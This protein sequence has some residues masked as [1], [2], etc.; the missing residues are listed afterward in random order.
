MC[1]RVGVAKEHVLQTECSDKLRSFGSAQLAPVSG[2]VAR[3]NRARHKK[4]KQ[5][6]YKVARIDPQNTL[7]QVVEKSVAVLPAHCYKISADDEKTVNGDMSQV[8]R[9]IVRQI[10][11]LSQKMLYWVKNLHTEKEWI[12]M[13][14]NNRTGQNNPQNVEVVVGGW[15][16]HSIVRQLR[17]DNNWVVLGDHTLQLCSPAHTTRAYPRRRSGI[18]MSGSES[19]VVMCD[20]SECHP[21]QGLFTGAGQV[22][23][24]SLYHIGGG[25]WR[26]PAYC[27]LSCDE[28]F[29]SSVTTPAAPRAIS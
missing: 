18:G 16:L 28:C 26:W 8:D 13:R 3:G 2:G 25:V 4:T 29:V 6:G 9:M 22:R 24:D 15:S 12:A 23:V 1:F 5:D 10:L 14:K 20:A 21:G 7:G 19:V 11:L 27:Q 17:L